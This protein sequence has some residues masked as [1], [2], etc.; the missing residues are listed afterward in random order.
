M[1]KKLKFE[2][3]EYSLVRNEVTQTVMVDECPF[4]HVLSATK[5]ER[6]IDEMQFG[7]IVKVTDLS[8][9]R[10]HN[11]LINGVEYQIGRASCRERV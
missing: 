8:M 4:Y 5:K 6:L 11:I 3:M 2:I 1:K 10:K 7:F 9:E